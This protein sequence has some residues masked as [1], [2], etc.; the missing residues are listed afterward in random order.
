MRMMQVAILLLAVGALSCGVAANALD[1]VAQEGKHDPSP[2]HA[3]SVAPADVTLLLQIDDAAAIRHDLADRPIA[4]WLTAMIEAS[5]FHQSWQRLAAQ[6][7]RESSDLFDRCFGRRVTLL[8]RRA[9]DG[10]ENDEWAL[11]TRISVNDSTDLLRR[12]QPRTLRSSFK[13]A[14]YELPEHDLLLA[15]RGETMLVGPRHS[16]LLMQDVLNR[17]GTGSGAGKPLSEADEFAA[18]RELRAGNIAVFMRHQQ[19][20]GGYSAAV[21]KRDGECVQLK[22]RARFD[23][24]PFS[25]AVTRI[26][27]DA[28]PLKALEDHALLAIIEPADIG[29]GPFETFI[30]AAIGEGLISPRTA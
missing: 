28:S 19:P 15:R 30:L 29:M 21:L 13:F 22:H 8:H 16:P 20:L 17:L 12:L 27:I 14:I 9:G 26:D 23:S 3:A 25:R 5:E 24:P 18:A 1:A 10:R 7:G 2:F 4:R 6:A 11:I